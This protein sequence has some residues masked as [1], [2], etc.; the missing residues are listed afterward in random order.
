MRIPDELPPW[1]SNRRS[2]GQCGERAFRFVWASK[3]LLARDDWYTPE[4]IEAYR[5]R[6]EAG[7]TGTCDALAYVCS[8]HF[9]NVANDLCDKY[10][11]AGSYTVRETWVRWVR[12]KVRGEWVHLAALARLDRC[13]L[14][15]R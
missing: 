8:K 12:R 9:N 2:C 4:V 3:S 5:K 11:E 15:A 7:N 13:A 14:L 6:I 10:G 1:R